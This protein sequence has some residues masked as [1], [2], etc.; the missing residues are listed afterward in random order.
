MS[1]FRIPFLFSDLQYQFYSRLFSI[2]VQFPI[3]E[4]IFL[5]QTH[6]TDIQT[7][8]KYSREKA[9]KVVFMPMNDSAYEN[10]K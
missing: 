8:G 3:N 9:S 1:I 10:K 2:S 4:I 5:Q 7:E 6:L